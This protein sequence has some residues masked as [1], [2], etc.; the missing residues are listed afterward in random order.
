M[1][2]G[3]PGVHDDDISSTAHVSASIA[4]K[5][6]HIS[7]AVKVLS[8]PLDERLIAIDRDDRSAGANE[9]GQDD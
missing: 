7:K 3:E 1:R 8:S 4:T 6:S 2:V 9:F 5:H